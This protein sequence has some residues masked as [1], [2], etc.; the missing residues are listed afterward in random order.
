MLKNAYMKVLIATRYFYPDITPRAFRSYELAKELSRLGHDVTVLTTRRNYDYSELVEATGI[1][2]KPIVLGEPKVIKGRGVTVRWLR[3]FLDYFFL[4]P[5]C[6]LAKRFMNG[7]QSE[8]KADLLISIAFPYPVHFGVA[9]AKLRNPNLC[10]VWVADCGDPFTGN[11]EARLPMPTYFKLLE[12]WLLRNAN[13]ISV[14]V[15]EAVDAYCG[16]VPEKFRVIPQ[17]FDFSKIVSPC[18]E[19]ENT[20]PTFSYAGNIS[21]GLRDPRPLLEFLEQSGK[22]F[23]FVIY[24]KNKEFLSSYVI[25]LNGMLEVRDY[26]PREDLLRILS[27]M[28]FLVNFENR[29][30]QQKPSKL[31]DYALTG[32]PILSIP[33]DG[34]DHDTVREFLCGNYENTLVVDDLQKYNIENVAKLFLELAG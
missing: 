24:T 13:Y 10:G 5:S 2:V 28:D 22:K 18:M 6:F 4:Y 8:P 19:P 26:V 32:R 1:K 31:I 14:P 20:V 23:K 12:I 17:G 27:G 3:F 30:G 25:R 34:L 9:L 33:F 29:G 16:G 21:D 7:L 11:K 15:P